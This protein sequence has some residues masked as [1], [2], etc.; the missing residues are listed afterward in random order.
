MSHNHNSTGNALKAALILAFLGAGSGLGH[1]ATV[2]FNVY[3]LPVGDSPASLVNG[4]LFDGR[5]I[6]GAVQNPDGSAT[7]C[8]FAPSR[9]RSPFDPV[10]FTAKTASMAVGK[11]GMTRHVTV[12]G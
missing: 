6:W 9:D 3:T 7:P 11:L 1:A 12:A 5:Y 4:V 8:F 2:S 10:M